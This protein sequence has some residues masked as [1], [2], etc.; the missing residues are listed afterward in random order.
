MIHQKNINYNLCRQHCVSN[1]LIYG[2]TIDRKHYKISTF[3]VL[4]IGIPIN[5]ASLNQIHM[6]YY[7]VG[8]DGDSSVCY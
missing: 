3:T 7:A 6:T 2:G 5:S 1:Q 4:H 8:T